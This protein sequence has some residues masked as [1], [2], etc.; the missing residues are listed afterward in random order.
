MLVDMAGRKYELP[1]RKFAIASALVNL[2]GPRLQPL[3]VSLC[4]LITL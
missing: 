3:M 4:R 2:T 1:R